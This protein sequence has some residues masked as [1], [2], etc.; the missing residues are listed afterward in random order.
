MTMLNS[1]IKLNLLLML[2]QFDFIVV[3]E[4]KLGFW[5]RSFRA[6]CNEVRTLLTR[7]EV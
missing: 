7:C 3:S 5:L 1:K 6:L 4:K 2:F